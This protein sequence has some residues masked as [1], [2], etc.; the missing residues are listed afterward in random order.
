MSR[1]SDSPLERIT[2][3]AT[4]RTSRSIRL[5]HSRETDDTKTDIINRHIQEGAYIEWVMAQPGGKVFIQEP[6]HERPQLLRLFGPHRSDEDPFERDLNGWE[7]GPDA[8]QGPD[9]D[10]IVREQ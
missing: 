8:A 2:F 4:N 7:T 9:V 1:A 10:I 5:T 6:G 3:N